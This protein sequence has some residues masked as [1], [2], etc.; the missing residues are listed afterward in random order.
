MPRSRE[1][2]TGQLPELSPES[3]TGRQNQSARAHR[4][5]TRPT[6][7]EPDLGTHCA[8]IA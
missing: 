8:G 4:E 7:P 5:T 3:A 2:K 6:H 1:E